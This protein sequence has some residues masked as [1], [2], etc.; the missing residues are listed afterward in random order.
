MPG[1]GNIDGDKTDKA[2][3][4]WVLKIFGGKKII[5]ETLRQLQIALASVV[6]CCPVY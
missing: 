3:L 1:V 2:Q 5:K 4:P 6:G